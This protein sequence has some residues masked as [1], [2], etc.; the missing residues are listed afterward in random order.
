MGTYVIHY[1]DGQ[2]REIPIIYGEDLRDWNLVPQE[3]KEATKAQLAWEGSSVGSRKQGSA[4]M[5]LFKRTWDNPVPDVEI[6][7]IDL[8]AAPATPQPFLVAITAE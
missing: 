3:P 4:S 2:Q 7:T 6:K 1:A 5:R 8:V